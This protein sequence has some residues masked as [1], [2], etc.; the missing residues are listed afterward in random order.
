MDERSVVEAAE[1]AISD[2]QA[3]CRVSSVSRSSRGA[4]WCIQFTEGY[5]QFCDSFS[6][7]FGKDESFLLRREKVKRYLFKCQEKLRRKLGSRRKSPRLTGEDHM[8]KRKQDRSALDTASKVASE[9]YDTASRAVG[10]AI[11]QVSSVASSARDAA[12]SATSVVSPTA[13]RVIKPRRGG[14]RSRGASSAQRTVERGVTQA[15][16]AVKRTTKAASRAAQRAAKATDRAAGRAASA[17]KRAAKAATSSRGAAKKSGK[18]ASAKKSSKATARKGAG[19]KAGAKK[20][21]RKK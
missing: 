17:T 15:R 5:G 3:S 2:L 16:K 20:S 8:A 13:A 18:K 14:S 9:I 6:D 11:E 21:A 1:A 10:N 7:E 19:R 12:A 4:G